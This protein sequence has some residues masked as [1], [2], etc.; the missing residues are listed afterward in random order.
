MPDCVQTLPVYTTTIIAEQ[1]HSGK[2][3][4]SIMWYYSM[5]N[6]SLQHDNFLYAIKHFC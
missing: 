5:T 1:L 2:A 6:S 3:N 4:S